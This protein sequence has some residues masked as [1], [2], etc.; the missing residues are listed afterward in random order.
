MSFSLLSPSGIDNSA[1]M[2]PSARAVPFGDVLVGPLACLIPM[3]AVA[4]IGRSKFDA[5]IGSRNSKTVVRSIINTHV[6][7]TLHVALDAFSTC[8][9]FK[10]NLPFFRSN[11][12]AFFTL[13]LVKMV[14]YRIINLCPMALETQTVAFLDRFYAVNIVAVT[15]AYITAVHLALRKGAVNIDFFQNLTIT[16]IQLL[17]EQTGQQAVQQVRFSMGVIFQNSPPGM[18]GCT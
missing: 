14:L 3:A 6:V 7:P 18:A 12:L 4:S 16:E 5:E 13:F 8:A 1:V 17:G 10:E 15:A 2:G 9:H 11:G